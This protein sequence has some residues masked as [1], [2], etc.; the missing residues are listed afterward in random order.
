MIMSANNDVSF[1]SNLTAAGNLTAGGT[2]TIYMGHS[3]F[4]GYLAA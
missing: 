1:A 2:V 3:S 4:W